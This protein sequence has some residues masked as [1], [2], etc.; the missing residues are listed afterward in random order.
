MYSSAPG[1]SGKV[2]FKAH[3]R[4]IPWQ[5]ASNQACAYSRSMAAIRI[6]IV[7]DFSRVR[8]D[9]RTVLTLAGAE[10]RQPIEVVGEAAT[11]LEALR[12]AN[13]LQPEVVLMDLEMP[14]MDG[15]EASRQIKACWPE[16]RVIAL[17]V[18]D[19]ET[20][21]QKALSAGMEA[22]VVKGAPVEVLLQA[23]FEK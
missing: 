9:L 20:A 17:T 6:L 8:E 13:T 12:L 2:R 1:W 21:Q 3:G 18:H 14:V 19:Y 11:G 10:H 7:D 15:F 22:F 16:C 23:I 4:F 5:D